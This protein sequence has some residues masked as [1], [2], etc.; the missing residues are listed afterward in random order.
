MR[1]VRTASLP[2]GAVLVVHSRRVGD[3]RWC[4]TRSSCRRR[5]R[6]KASRRSAVQ[7]PRL[8]LSIRLRL[9]RRLLSLRVAA[10]HR[11]SRRASLRALLRL[12]LR[13]KTVAG[14]LRLLLRK[15]WSR[16]LRLSRAGLHTAVGL[17]PR[18]R[19]SLSLRRRGRLHL[20]LLL[21]GGHFG[22]RGCAAFRYEVAW[23]RDEGCEEGFAENEGVQTGLL[24]RPSLFRVEMQQ[25]LDKVD[26][27][28]PVSHLCGLA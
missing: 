22:R 14:R 23:R 7:R 27:R 17:L 1:A 6:R 28:D 26:E 9:R 21:G 13:L 18:L 2:T 3:G 20:L 15:V 10:R 16:L 25:A 8:S 11:V 4:R 24:R 19:L 12:L 5:P